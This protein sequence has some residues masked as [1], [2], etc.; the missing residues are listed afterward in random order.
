MIDT[1]LKGNQ[2]MNRIWGGGLYQRDYLYEVAEKRGLLV[3]YIT[4]KIIY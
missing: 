4:I 1:A 3:F 2:N